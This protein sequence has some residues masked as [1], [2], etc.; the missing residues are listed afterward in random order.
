MANLLDLRE[1]VRRG[2]EADMTLAEFAAGDYF[3]VKLVVVAEEQVLAD[4]NLS[5]RADQTFPIVRIALELARQKDFD[6]SVKEVAAGGIAGAHG[7]GME[8]GATSVEARG[9]DF[10]VV[11]D[12]QVGGAEEI[13]EVAECAV[14]KNSCAGIEVEQAG[15]G[16]VGERL[17]GDEFFGEVEVEIGDLH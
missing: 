12:Q 10:R 17:L 5:A 3:G 7:F 6:A 14:L 9:E 15:G 1:E 13:G 8:S 2:G 16:T 4:G 11:E